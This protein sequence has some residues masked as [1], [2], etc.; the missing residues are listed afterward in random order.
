[1]SK[2]SEVKLCQSCGM[3]ID[4]RTEPGTEKDGSSSEKYCVHCY[5][6]GEFTKNGSFEEMYAYNLARFRESD[7]NRF[8]K[9]ILN[10]MYTKK[11]V[12]K[13]ERWQEE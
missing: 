5:Q 13:L 12:K 1:M 9:F 8:E 3:P 10:M 11:F 6:N 2:R 4:V 7:M